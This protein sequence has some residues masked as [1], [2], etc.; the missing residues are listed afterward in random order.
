MFNKEFTLFKA[1]TIL[2]RKSSLPQPQTQTHC[3]LSPWKPTWKSSLGEVRRSWRPGYYSSCTNDALCQPMASIK[4]VKWGGVSFYY[5]LDLLFFLL[6]FHQAAEASCANSIPNKPL[7]FQK[8]C[9]VPRTDFNYFHLKVYELL[10]FCLV[11]LGFFVSKKC[12]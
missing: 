12:E 10:G 9:V 2:F 11:S 8:K 1:T 4:N 5:I 7:N 6:Q 3:L